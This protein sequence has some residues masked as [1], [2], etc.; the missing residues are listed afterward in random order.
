M[1]SFPQRVG[2]S[3]CPSL[4][5]PFPLNPH[6]RRTPPQVLHTTNDWGLIF[7]AAAA[8]YAVGA[9]AFLRWASSDEQFAT[10]PPAGKA[11]A[12]RKQR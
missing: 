4:Q 3:T 9:L 6:T 10:S 5:P 8:T 7:E 1:H 11:A 12:A 2:N